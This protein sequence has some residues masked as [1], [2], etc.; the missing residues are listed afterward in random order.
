VGGRGGRSGDEEKERGKLEVLKRFFLKG[1][2]ESSF[3]FW[4]S[5]GILNP[6]FE[7][8]KEKAKI[9]PKNKKQKRNSKTNKQNKQAKKI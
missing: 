4:N 2:G 5:F 7:T 3:F 8:L 6:Y 9:F 1:D